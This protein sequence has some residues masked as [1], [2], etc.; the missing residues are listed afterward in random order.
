MRLK[1]EHNYCRAYIDYHLMYTFVQKWAFYGEI[2]IWSVL[3]LKAGS[4]MFATI[5][6]VIF[7]KLL[8]V[9]VSCAVKF[10]SKGDNPLSR[11]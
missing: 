3:N 2:A 7:F 6:A 1:R 9:C 8:S 11:I 10:N 4:G 5:F